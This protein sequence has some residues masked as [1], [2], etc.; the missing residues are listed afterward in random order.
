M[1]SITDWLGV[2]I[3]AA[4]AIGAF[5]SYIQAKNEKEQAQES[6]QKNMQKQQQNI[7]KAQC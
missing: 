3:S 6:E 2:I 1:P 7:M 4:C 5:Y